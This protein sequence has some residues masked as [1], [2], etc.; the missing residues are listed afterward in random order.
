MATKDY[1]A[2]IKAIE[3]E[4]EELQ[5]ESFSNAD[6][7]ELGLAIVERARERSLAITVDICRAGQQLFHYAFSGTSADNDQWVAR[8][9]RVVGRFDHASL[10]VGFKLAKEGLSI[11]EKFYVSSLE[12]S[13]FGGAFP[14]ILK[15]TG[16]VGTATVSGLAQEDDHAL[17]VESLRAFLRKK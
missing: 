6:A 12:Y 14:I 3:G 1:D 10:L 5:F 13:P 7:L 9:N 8:K 16:V 15:G 11:E 4:E 2:L 17:V